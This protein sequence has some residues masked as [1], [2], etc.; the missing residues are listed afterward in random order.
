MIKPSVGRVVWFYPHVDA[1][2]DPNGQPLAALVAKVIDD[3]TINL[4]AVGADGTPFAAQHVPLLQGGELAADPDAARAEWMPYQKGQAAKTE[5]LQAA[6]AAPA[7]DL[8]EVHAKLAELETGIGGKFDE[9]GAWLE[10]HVKD[11]HARL[12]ALEKPA[13]A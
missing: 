1:G 6:A 7:P 8:S 2:R 9:L 5:A 12:A 3:S 11:V 13:A 10:T 4:L